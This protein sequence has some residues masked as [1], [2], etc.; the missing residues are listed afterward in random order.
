MS[1]FFA[2]AGLG[3]CSD[4]ATSSAT[5]SGPDGGATSDGPLADLGGATAD[6][7]GGHDGPNRPPVITSQAPTQLDIEIAADPAFA[8]IELT[9]TQVGSTANNVFS[10]LPSADPKVFGFNGADVR[11]VNFDTRPDGTAI[12]SGTTLTNEY[13]S[14][15]V[16]MRNI[17]VANNV[18]GG[19]ASPPNA[20]T[21]VRSRGAPYTGSTAR[22]RG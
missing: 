21:G 7:G 6:T 5:A 12:P 1:P 13:E 2:T 3:A 20:H 19:P 15:G 16:V 4:D 17:T 18:Y 14:L 8:A 11:K 9:P 22:C 10:T